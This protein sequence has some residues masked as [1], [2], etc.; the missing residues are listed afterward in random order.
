MTSGDKSRV[1]AV[2]S[3][4]VAPATTLYSSGNGRRVVRLTASPNA[5]LVAVVDQRL[6]LDSNERPTFAERLEGTGKL[7]AGIE[8]SV[9]HVVGTDGAERIAVPDVRDFAWAP[10]GTKLAVVTGRYTGHDLPYVDLK[11]SIVDIQTQLITTIA[12]RGNFVSWTSFDGAIYIWVVPADSEGQVLK[13]S[14][15]ESKLELTGRKSIYFSP[16]GKYYYRPAG[17]SGRPA[18][19]RSIDDSEVSGTPGLA[20]IAPFA[21]LGWSPDRDLLLVESA[22][23]RP[24]ERVAVRQLVSDVDSDNTFPIAAHVV[25]WAGRGQ[26]LIVDGDKPTITQLAA[27]G[28]PR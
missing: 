15:S 18:L 22:P 8:E 27:V 21:P 9:L 10:D 1:V 2:D 24:G 16:S 20:A 4:G 13:Y 28:V 12:E 23:H 26:G 19:F 11:T 5:A 17:I 25:G 6:S 14:L 3:S 7:V